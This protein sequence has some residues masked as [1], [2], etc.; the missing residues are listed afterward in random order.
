[1]NA[2]VNT[3]PLKKM[4]LPSVARFFFALFIPMA[5]LLGGVITIL[6]FNETANRQTALKLKE[7]R[8][9]NTQRE[10]ISYYIKVIA[11]DV[12]VV[13]KLFEADG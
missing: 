8:R 7:I 10:V 12:L 6:Y 2:A 3:K 13:S 11:T 1:M 4:N 9:L 5:F